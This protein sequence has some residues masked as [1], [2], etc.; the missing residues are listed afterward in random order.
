MSLNTRPLRQVRFNDP[1]VL[2]R[3]RTE[4]GVWG[5]M[6]RI[7]LQGEPKPLPC[8]SARFLPVLQLLRHTLG[9]ATA[10]QTHEEEQDHGHRQ[11]AQ[12]VRLGGGRENLPG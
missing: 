11:H 2:P 10:Q 5:V 4:N 12:D 9:N 6:G 7:G 1:S 8:M 3:P